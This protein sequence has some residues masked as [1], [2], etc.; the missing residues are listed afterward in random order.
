MQCQLYFKILPSSSIINITGSSVLVRHFYVIC[1]VWCVAC[2]ISMEN[3]KKLEKIGEGTYGVV[4]KAKNIKT[5]A[6][7][8]LKKIRLDVYVTN[9]SAEF[10]T[11]KHS[12][13]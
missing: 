10:R 12:G 5:G 9:W 3:F 1:R 11:W 8:A 6:L 4:Y 13:L 7:V 2:E